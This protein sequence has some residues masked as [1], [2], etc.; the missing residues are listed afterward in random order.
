[1]TNEQFKDQ[2]ETMLAEIVAINEAALEAIE[3]IDVSQYE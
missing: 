1:M 3:R 2:A